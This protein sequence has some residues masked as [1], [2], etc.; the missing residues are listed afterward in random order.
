[1]AACLS[2]AQAFEYSDIIGQSHMGNATFEE[3]HAAYPG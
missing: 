3:I 2:G 1:V